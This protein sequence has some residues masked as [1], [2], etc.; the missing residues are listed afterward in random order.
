M[1]KILVFHICLLLCII[2]CIIKQY[3]DEYKDEVIVNHHNFPYPKPLFIGTSNC[4]LLENEQIIAKSCDT[5][6]LRRLSRKAEIELSK[7]IN[8]IYYEKEIRKG[9]VTPLDTIPLYIR[10][11]FL[12]GKL[13]LQPDI[14]SLILLEDKES[15]ADT[16]DNSEKKGLWLVNINEEKLFS[17][18]NLELYSSI[19]IGIKVTW[20]DSTY[21]H[22]DLFS[23]ILLYTDNLLPYKEE[24]DD[25][26]RMHLIITEKGYVKALE[27]REWKSFVEN[28]DN[29]HKNKFI[30]NSK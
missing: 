20:S 13:D 15:K 6:Q 16:L 5:M 14:K 8:E 29:K 24:D 23:K 10:K 26:N 21:I 12:Y 7:R 17:I 2:S 3:N 18:V 22:T 11:F 9:K 27:K 28:I 19:F 25:L 4:L 30:E 1:K